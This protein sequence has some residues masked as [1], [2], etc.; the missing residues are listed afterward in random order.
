MVDVV[1]LLSQLLFTNYRQK[2]NGHNDQVY[3][4]PSYQDTVISLGFTKF[5]AEI[6]QK[7]REIEKKTW[8]NLH[9]EPHVFKIEN[10]N[11]DLPQYGIF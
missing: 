2:P 9:L 6:L 4:A 11:I 5:V 10:V 1:V 3:S 8:P 7:Y